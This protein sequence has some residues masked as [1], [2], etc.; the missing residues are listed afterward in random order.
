MMVLGYQRT[1]QP[2]DLW[3]MDET[4]ESGHLSAI[5]DEAWAR[6]LKEANAWN[7]RLAN[8]EIKPG[9]LKRLK[10]AISS[11]RAGT[12]YADRRASLETQWREV[13]GRKEPSLAWALNDT[14]GS[15]FWIGG[16]FKVSLL[17]IAIKFALIHSLHRLWETLPSLW[18]LYSLRCG[19]TV[20]QLRIV[21]DISFRRLSTLVKLISLP[22]IMG[23]PHLVWVGV[24]E[25]LLDF[26]VS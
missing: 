22:P 10:W 17:I 20:I 15:L 23:P 24:L 1:L 12:K 2:T 18:D 19:I 5:L 25:W 16:L 6:R 26:F 7:D 8:G 9:F 3:K 13:D 11:T 14:L 4:R 21:T